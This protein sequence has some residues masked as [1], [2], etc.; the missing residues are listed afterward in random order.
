MEKFILGLHLLV[1]YCGVLN[2]LEQSPSVSKKEDDS[3]KENYLF[4]RPFADLFSLCVAP[5]FLVC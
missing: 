4:D 2:F 5:L 1:V 3:V